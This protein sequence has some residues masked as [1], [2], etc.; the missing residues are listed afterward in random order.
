M[1][2]DN[3]E[4]THVITVGED[5]TVQKKMNDAV[6][7]AEKLAS[8]GRLA[9]GVVHEL[10]NP[11]ATIAACTEAL[12]SRLEQIENEELN[13]DF[14]EYLEIIRDEAFRCKTINNSLLD[15]SHQRQAEK[16]AGDINQIID[17]TLQLI[18]HHPKLGKMNV[19]KELDGTLSPVYVNEG[20]MK[21]IFIALISNAYDAMENGGTLTIR[22][23]WHDTEIDKV[24]RSVCAEFM[25]T[26][27]GIPGSHLAKIFD[28]F[29]TTKPLGRGTGLGLSVC[30]GI[31][32]EHGGRIEVDS[33]EGTG[34]TFRIL[35]PVKPDINWGGTL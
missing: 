3:A 11:L 31:V 21:Q 15:F 8:I 29:F 30:Y 9:A 16:M 34:S 7:H 20:Q 13:K 25:D 4:V 32:S 1:R 10:N 26:G 33:T 12:T 2:V 14:N 17:Q 19:I 24:D 22:T 5:I 18:K 28:P 23:R 6:I 35:L 27:C